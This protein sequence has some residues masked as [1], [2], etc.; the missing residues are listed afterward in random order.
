MSLDKVVVKV[1]TEDAPLMAKLRRLKIIEKDEN[2]E[3]VWAMVGGDFVGKDMKVAASSFKMYLDNE[4]E[5][6]ED[7]GRKL[8]MG[9]PV[10]L[11]K[12]CPQCWKPELNE[13]TGFTIAGT[14]HQCKGNRFIDLNR[15]ANTFKLVKK[16]DGAGTFDPTKLPPPQKAEK[17]EKAVGKGK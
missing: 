5:V 2:G 8:L 6:P 10:P 9:Y 1:N 13:S 4:V 15:T 16:V 17:A 14:C 3:F 11:D 12:P 7:F